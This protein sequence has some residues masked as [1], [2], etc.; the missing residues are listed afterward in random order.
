MFSLTFVTY[1][2]VLFYHVFLTLFLFFFFLSPPF[3]FLF[4]FFFLNEPAPPEIYPLSLHDALPICQEEALAAANAEIA[5]GPSRIAQVDDVSSEFVGM[6]LSP[7]HIRPRGVERV[8]VGADFSAAL[9]QGAAAKQVGDS[10]GCP[11]GPT[12]HWAREIVQRPA[13]V[14]APEQRSTRRWLL[15][16]SHVSPFA[17]TG[18]SPSAPHPGRRTRPTS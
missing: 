12:A 8:V 18:A 15:H 7:P 6:A 1:S 5:P 16:A 3:L 14:G 10:I 17:S 13:T 4:F 2:I 9:G 11:I